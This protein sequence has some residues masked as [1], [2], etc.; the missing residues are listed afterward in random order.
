M[1]LKEER[2][3]RQA[4][5]ERRVY[6]KQ[7][8]RL[9]VQRRE[10]AQQWALKRR[11]AEQNQEIPQRTSNAHMPIQFCPKRCSYNK[12]GISSWTFACNLG[13][14]SPYSNA[15]PDATRLSVWTRWLQ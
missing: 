14:S 15:E 2:E 7:V 8:Q 9:E 11:K 10:Q 6:N 1:R 3:E 4:K 5:S 13:T 12:S